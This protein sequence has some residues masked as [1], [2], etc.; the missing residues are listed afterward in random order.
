MRIW[1][2][3]ILFSALILGACESLPPLPGIPGSEATAQ[4]TGTVSPAPGSDK[5]PQSPPTQPGPIPL[6]IWIPPEMDPEAEDKAAALFRSRLEEF[7]DLHEGV[8]L[9]VRIK[10]ESGTAGLLESLSTTSAAAP[11]AL[12]DLI[13]LPNADLETAALKGLLHP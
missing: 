3:L 12:P 2:I 10:S 11:L 9:D 4:P 8:R 5:T 13:A 6:R 7:V 1:H